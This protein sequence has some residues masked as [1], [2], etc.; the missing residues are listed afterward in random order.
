MK[1]TAT[2][3]NYNT[4]ALVLAICY[5]NYITPEEALNIVEGGQGFKLTEQDKE[6]MYKLKEEGLTYTEI[7][8]MYGYTDTRVYKIIKRY[9]EKYKKETL[10]GGNLS[11]VSG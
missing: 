6:D 11:K 8:K 10:Q 3:T 7:G 9:K 5:Q 1:L 2:D 4:A